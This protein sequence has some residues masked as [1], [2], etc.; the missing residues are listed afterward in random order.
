M[1]LGLLIMVEVGAVDVTTSTDLLTTLA[2]SI[3]LNQDIVPH[4]KSR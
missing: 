2:V 1:T 3:G 4:V